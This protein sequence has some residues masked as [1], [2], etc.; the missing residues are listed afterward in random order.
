MEIE[1]KYKNYSVDDFVE[2]M[3]F[4]NWITSPNEIL[5]SFWSNFKRDH[6]EKLDSIDLARKIVEAL[7]FEEKDFAKEEYQDSIDRLKAY[8]DKKS[9]VQTKVGWLASNWRKVAA[10]LLL[11]VIGLS[12]YL[13]VGKPRYEVTGQMVQYIVPEGQKSKVILSDGSMVWLNSGSTL[14]VS[15][16]KGENRKV[17]LSGEA[18]FEVIKNPKEP[19]VVK[20]KCYSVKVFGT[21]FNVRSYNNQLESETVLKEG[22]ISIISQTQEEL[23]MVPGQRFFLDSEKKHT[24]SEVDPDVYTSWKENVL[25]IDNE[26]LQDLMVQMEH[27]YGIKIQIKDFDRVKNLRYTLTIKTESLREM[28]ELMNFVTPLKYKIDGERVFLNYNK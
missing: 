9:S 28:L 27:W 18:Y 11:P 15:L 24:L 10:I 17:Q 25:K 19:F 1:S 13:S 6:P 23:K 22:S 20:T 16:D 2:D 26:R 21:K 7:I 4:R 3:N 5:D 8:L 14:S 12:L